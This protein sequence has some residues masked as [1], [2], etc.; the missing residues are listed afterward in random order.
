MPHPAL[1]LV[2]G[3]CLVA[4]GDPATGCPSSPL[5]MQSKEKRL[6]R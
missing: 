3:F 1:L 2:V 5:Q 4:H 6:A